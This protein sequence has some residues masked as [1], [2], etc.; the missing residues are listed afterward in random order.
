MPEKSPPDCVCHVFT[1]KDGL[2][3]AVA[4]DLEL[5]VSRWSVRYD[6]QAITARFDASSLRVVSPLSA[7]QKA[8]IEA[9]IVR[10]VLR[11]KRYPEIAFRSTR[12][13]ANGAGG[14]SVEGLLTL[15]GVERPLRFEVA[16]V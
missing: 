15:T 4:H 2:L 10:D 12:I 6:E 13:A 11:A 8:E 9:N 14:Y 16:R 3:S 1:F 7:E 5:E